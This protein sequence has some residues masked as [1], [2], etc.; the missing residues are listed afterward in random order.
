MKFRVCLL[1]QSVTFVDT[2]RFLL[3]CCFNKTLFQLLFSFLSHTHTQNVELH[4]LSPIIHTLK[5]APLT[6]TLKTARLTHTHPRHCNCKAQTLIHLSQ[7][8]IKNT[9]YNRHTENKFPLGRDF[10]PPLFKAGTLTP[11]YL[12]QGL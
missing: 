6:H 10:N 4:P 7:N 12:R 9:K 1:Q 5:T 2:V 11:L 8:T 3:L